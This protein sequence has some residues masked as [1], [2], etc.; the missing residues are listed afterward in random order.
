[1]SQRLTGGAYTE[2]RT[3]EGHALKRGYTEGS[4]EVHQIGKGKEKM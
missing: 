3:P 1:M 4:G 2:G